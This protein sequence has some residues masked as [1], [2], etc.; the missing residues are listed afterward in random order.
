ML[1]FGALRAKAVW[2]GV[3]IEHE[4]AV[5]VWIAETPWPVI[6]AC[7]A[8]AALLYIGWYARGQ[9][10]YLVGAFVCLVLAVATFFVERYLVTESE[11][12][13]MVLEEL[14][15]AVKS[16]DD[17]A[18]LNRISARAPDLRA[19]VA[20]AIQRYQVSDEVRLTQVQVE[21]TSQNSRA[22]TRFRANG[23]ISQAGSGT[24]WRGVTRWE[25]TWQRE[26]D[27]WRIIRITR[28]DPLTG[29]ELSPFWQ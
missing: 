11:R 17:E 23:P 24:T 20:H 6:V 2:F 21:L 18:V 27:E 15:S 28:L 19:S 14:W 10:G 7:S 13:E 8:V 29:E 12:V 26:A 1:P 4:G 22:L 3:T 16:D 5:S 25:F 9:G